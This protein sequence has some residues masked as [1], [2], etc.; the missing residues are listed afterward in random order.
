MLAALG[1]VTIGLFL[2]LTMTKRLSVLTALV[3]VPVAAAVVGGFA[4]QLGDL[5]AEGMLTVAPVAIMITFAVLYFSLMVDEGLFDPAIRRILRW[6]KGDPMK[7]TV[8]TAVL[9][10][11]VALDGDGASTFLI[12][13]SA[14]L[15]VYRRLGMSPL[16][17]SG[18]VCL[19]ALGGA[20]GRVERG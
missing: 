9:T 6:A 16:V 12:T 11:L 3:L 17:L 2:F 7:I 13:V 20:R 1:F 14:L 18:V 5:V 10:L 15:P 8:G 19:G 4:G